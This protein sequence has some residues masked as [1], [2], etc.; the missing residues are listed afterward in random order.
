[1][2]LEVDMHPLWLI[3]VICVLP[4]TAGKTDTSSW[5]AVA[6][7]AYSDMQ[8]H[9][10]EVPISGITLHRKNNLISIVYKATEI[11]TSSSYVSFRSTDP[12]INVFKNCAGQ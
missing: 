9:L 7:S 5:L 12:P 11:A 6:A 8:V 1:M 3:N 4:C 2:T 10:Y